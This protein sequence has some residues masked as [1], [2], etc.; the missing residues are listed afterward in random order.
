MY[1]AK[2]KKNKG[3]P[4]TKALIAPDKP[5]PRPPVMRT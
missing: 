2:A 1:D 4:D 3:K 5:K